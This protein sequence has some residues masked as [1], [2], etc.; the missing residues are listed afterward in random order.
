VPDDI[1]DFGDSNATNRVRV[2]QN[3]IFSATTG[4]ELE[5]D[6][7]YDRTLRF[8]ASGAII[9]ISSNDTSTATSAPQHSFSFL[10]TKQFNENY[11]GSL[12]YYFVEKFKWTDSRGGTDD[13]RTLDMKLSRN[14]RFEKSHGSISLV[15]KNLLGEYSDYQ[16]NPSNAPGNGGSDT[17]PRVVHAPIAYIDFRL[18]F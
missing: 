12:G 11:N 1:N 13:F 16:E 8:I 2:F 10:T 14:L 18:N 15:L 17:A 6:Y 9:N 4:L 7:R 5:L 3:R